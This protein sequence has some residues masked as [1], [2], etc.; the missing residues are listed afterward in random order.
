MITHKK[1]QW[2]ATSDEDDDDYSH[3]LIIIS[4]QSMFLLKQQQQQLDSGWTQN[5][6]FTFKNRE[7]EE[8]VDSKQ[9]HTQSVNRKKQFNRI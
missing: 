9:T 5:E 3:Y 6:F 4:K 8:E 2:K 1:K 7:K